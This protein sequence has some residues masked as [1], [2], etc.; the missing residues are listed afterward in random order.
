MQGLMMQHE[1]MISDLIESIVTHG[2]TAPLERVNLQM[3]CLMLVL[4]KVI[5]S[6]RLRG[7]IIVTLRSITLC[8]LSAR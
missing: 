2:Q 5:V 1:L 4:K 8:H 6:R 3:L 7:I